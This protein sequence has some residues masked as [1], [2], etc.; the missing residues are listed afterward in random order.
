MLWN[1]LSI[2][3]DFNYCRSRHQTRL[4]FRHIIKI[5]TIIVSVMDV[6]QEIDDDRGQEGAN[7]IH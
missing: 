2:V 1:D 3:M 4:V 5:S 6:G 7:Q